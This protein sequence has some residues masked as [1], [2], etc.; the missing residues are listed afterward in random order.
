MIFLLIFIFILV[1]VALAFVVKSKAKNDTTPSELVVAEDCC[2]AHEV[3]ET[4]SLLAYT[5][6]ADYYEDEELDL[7]IGVRTFDYTDRDI[8]QFR[9]V[10]YTL[11][12][13]EVASWLKSLQVRNIQLPHV[14]REEALM[15][16]AER[17]SRTARE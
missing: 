2:G 6:K 8:E 16:V 9:E 7:F 17:R 13:K 1:V 3:C 11:K 4:D 12:E 14:I 10:L 5:D 15:I